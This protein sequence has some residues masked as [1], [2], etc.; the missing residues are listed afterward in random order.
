MAGDRD[1]DIA[2][3]ATGA[4]F[5]GAYEVVRCI[6]AGGMGAVYEVLQKNTERRRAL[7]V[8]LPSLVSDPEMRARFELEAKI[9]AGIESEHIVET[10]DAGVDEATGMPFIVMELLK[11]EEIGALLKVRKRLPPEEVVTLLHQ[12]ALALD[13]THA[14]GII[15]RDLKPENLFLTRRDDGSPRLKILDFGVAKIVAD[16]TGSSN[17][18]KSVG[19]PLYMAPEQIA[20]EAIGPHVDRYSLA[21]IAFT[22]LVGKPYWA[23]ERKSAQG[24]YPYLMLVARGAQV[25]SSER[26]KELGVSLPPAFDGWFSRATALDTSTRFDGSVA[27]VAA[28][29]E[30][31]DV[32]PP[33]ASTPPPGTRAVLPSIV[34]E[35]ARELPLSQPPPADGVITAT[36][37]PVPAYVAAI[38]ASGPSPLPSSLE[39]PPESTSPGADPSAPALTRSSGEPLSSPAEP[40]SR[41]RSSVTPLFALVL[42]FAGVGAVGAALAFWP[43]GGP[44]AALPLPSPTMAPTPT[45]GPTSSSPAPAAVV[46]AAL[47]SAEPTTIP[48]PVASASAAPVG[49]PLPSSS[50]ATPVASAASSDKP[51]SP[52]PSTSG[53]SRGKPAGTGTSKTPPK[54]KNPLDEY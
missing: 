18:T 39:P 51:A 50:S 45:P 52:L 27:M 3:L 24:L 12:A 46:P 5:H 33:A 15:H 41:R 19:S 11:G 7:K 9:A 22:M 1:A 53:W 4:L 10:L 21:H 25:P 28:L 40:R 36:A 14:A 44:R 13:R 38:E 2:V 35:P 30:A 43:K 23:R 6:K 8:M 47:S 26:A 17:T 48:E 34:L 32:K 37:P 16:G 42:L 54:G 49:E 29:A 20:G 31:F